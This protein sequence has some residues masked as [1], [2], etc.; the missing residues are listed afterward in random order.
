[1]LWKSSALK[2]GK[3]NLLAK[4]GKEPRKTRDSI[5]SSPP[6]KRETGSPWN[7]FLPF[8]TGQNARP[9][10]LRGFP[11]LR[12]GV[13]G[14]LLR[15]NL[16]LNLRLAL[17]TTPDRALSRGARLRSLLFVSNG[18]FGTRYATHIVPLFRVLRRLLNQ[19]ESHAY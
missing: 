2:R 14:D 4:C 7:S 1:M 18:Q 10:V 19:C 5:L 9:A 3:S 15:G 13:T 16:R 11:G 6:G 12:V 17:R 8:T